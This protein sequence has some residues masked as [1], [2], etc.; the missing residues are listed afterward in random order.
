M[1][2]EGLG[3]KSM[4]LSVEQTPSW[5]PFHMSRTAVANSELRITFALT[6]LGTAQIDD[7]EVRVSTTDRVGSKVPVESGNR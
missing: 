6:G 7:V 5:E 4:A 1:V 2:C 3:G